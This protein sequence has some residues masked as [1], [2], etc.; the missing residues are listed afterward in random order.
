MEY[1]GMGITGLLSYMGSFWTRRF[2]IS[3][4][5]LWT[6]YEQGV[7]VEKG[8]LLFYLFLQWIVL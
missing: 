7:P 2:S 3:I 8:T 5:S 4:G 1:S 6:L